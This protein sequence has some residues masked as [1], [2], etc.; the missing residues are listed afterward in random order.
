MDWDI[1]P[2]QIIL[3]CQG[4]AVIG[5]SLMLIRGSYRGKSEFLDRKSPRPRHDYFSRR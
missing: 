3:A 5:V 2:L 4:L 1:L